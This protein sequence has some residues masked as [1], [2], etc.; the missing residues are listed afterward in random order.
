[1]TSLKAGD[2]VPE[3]VLT[4]YDGRKMALAEFKGKQAVVL[5]FYPA[6]NTPICTREACS[7]RD[8]Y[9]DF[10]EAGA[11]VF[12]VS[13]DTQNSHRQFAEKQRLPYYLVSDVDGSLRRAFG[14]P[15]KFGLLTGRVTYV[16]DREGVVQQVLQYQFAGRKHMEEAL[17]AV[18]QLPRQ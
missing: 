5:F 1:M 12:G 14:V 15:N 13:G 18:R 2:R 4:L 11:A 3:L 17:R 16:I 9:H 6:D 7:F 8:A 10:L